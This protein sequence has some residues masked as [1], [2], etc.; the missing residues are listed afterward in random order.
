MHTSCLLDTGSVLNFVSRTLM[1]KMG[2]PQPEGTWAGSI[3]T[4]SGVKSIST[5]FHNL[6][7]IDVR[8]TF[9]FIR[10]LEIYSIGQSS[11]LNFEDFMELCQ[12]LKINPKLVQRPK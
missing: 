11:N 4:V 8:G 3:K 6:C 1:D 12:V 5:P 2:R 10:A 7:L 9:H